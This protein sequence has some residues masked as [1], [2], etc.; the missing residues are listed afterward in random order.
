MQEGDFRLS[1]KCWSQGDDENLEVAGG[2]V[3]DL[4]FIVDI[5]VGNVTKGE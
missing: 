5:N 1:T 4:E 3:L 2:K